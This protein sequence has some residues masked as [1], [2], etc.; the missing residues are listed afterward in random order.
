M[1]SLAWEPISRCRTGYPFDGL[2][3]IAFEALAKLLILSLSG[4]EAGLEGSDTSLIVGA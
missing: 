4:S 3:G 2:G 1:F